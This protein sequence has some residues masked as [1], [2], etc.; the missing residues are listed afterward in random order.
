M[1]ITI[2]FIDETQI[3]YTDVADD[4]VTPST[5]VCVRV[6]DIAFHGDFAVVKFTTLEN[7][8]LTSV[9]WPAHRIRGVTW[10]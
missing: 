7:G 4:R 9:A 2:G 10:S 3:T 1:R 6:V 8:P 5:I